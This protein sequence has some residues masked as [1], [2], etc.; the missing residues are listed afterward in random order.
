MGQGL[1]LVNSDA[2]VDPE[3]GEVL[4]VETRT[5]RGERVVVAAYDQDAA[6]L[7]RWFLRASARRLLMQIEQ[8]E[9]RVRVAYSEFA[10][11]SDVRTLRVRSVRVGE[12]FRLETA[13]RREYVQADGDVIA[14]ALVAE[15]KRAARFRVINCCRSKIGRTVEPEIWYS[16]R[17]QRA[18]YHNLQVCG[19]VWTCPVCSRRINLARQR[20]IR[21]AYNLFLGENGEQGERVADAMMITFTVK[22]GVGDDLADLFDKLKQADRLYLQKSYAYKCL[23]GYQRTLKGARVAVR[24]E[25]DYLGRIAA[26]EV[27]HG[28][29]GWHP[30]SHQLWFFDR[31]LTP[32]EQA[33]LRRDLFKEWRAACLAV[34]LPAPAEFVQGR[35]V[36]VDVRRALSADEYLT[37]FGH[38]RLWG[39]EREIASQ[40]TK[41][42]RGGRSPF[43][44][45]FDAAQGDAAAGRLFRVFADA[46]LGR[47]QLEFSKGLRAR[48]LELGLDDVLASDEALA[49]QEVGEDARPLGAFSDAHFEAM[50]AADEDGVVEPFGT[51]LALA[52]RGGFEAARAF[53]ESLPGY[54]DHVGRRQ[55]QEARQAEIAELQRDFGLRRAMLSDAAAAPFEDLAASIRY[56]MDEGERL[57]AWRDLLL[58]I[59]NLN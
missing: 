39:P 51:V 18:G 59:R 12:R 15:E 29:N 55:A 11:A 54:V 33:R 2:H 35:A 3:T 32:G 27:T 6:D 13:Y 37:K 22:H 8:R 41:G 50:L 30:H 48:L 4:A 58:Q 28:R 34:G 42:G 1:A 45:L 43:Q 52:K 57:A 25:L 47:H 26:T 14:G 44:L 20:Q 10:W 23:V 17:S 31:R 5:V 40:H 9:K 53:I 56:V 46:T 7:E 19:S 24:S 49:A 16:Q 21:A 36:G 38:E